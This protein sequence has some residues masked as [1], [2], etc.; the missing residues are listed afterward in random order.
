MK[1]EAM[2]S[3]CGSLSMAKGDIREC[4]DE[5]VLTDLISAGYVREVRADPNQKK[6]TAR[7]GVKKDES[8]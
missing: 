4:S 2:K 5:T 8:K 7:R 6:A 1:I 3:F